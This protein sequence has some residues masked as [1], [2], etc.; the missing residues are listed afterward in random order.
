MPTAPSAAAPRYV[1]EYGKM[2]SGAARR[3]VRRTS[4]ICNV[5]NTTRAGI[6]SALIELSTAVLPCESSKNVR[7]FPST[8]TGT[9]M[10][11][12]WMSIGMVDVSPGANQR[13][14]GTVGSGTGDCG[15]IGGVVA[16][17]PAASRGRCGDG[18]GDTDGDGNGE[19]NDGGSGGGVGVGAA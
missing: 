5:P 6:G 12:S 7:R 10:T 13:E 11:P 19:G 1:T 14:S 4:P 2:R 15:A 18:G 17:I 9:K 16:L 8:T 3:L